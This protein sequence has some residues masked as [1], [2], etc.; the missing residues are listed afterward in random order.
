MKRVLVAGAI[1][2]TLISCSGG[3]DTCP[4]NIASY[5][6]DFTV[7]GIADVIVSGANGSVITDDSSPVSIDELQLNVTLDYTESNM[8]SASV[9]RKLRSMLSGLLVKPAFACS[10]R[11]HR[12]TTRVVGA[13]LIS[14]SSFN[15]SY[16]PGVSL[17]GVFS[18]EPQTADFADVQFTET[19][20]Q[21]SPEYPMADS[22][23]FTIK[24]SSLSIDTTA[25]HRFSLSIDLDNGQSFS[26]DTIA[27]LISG[28]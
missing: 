1:V 22:V 5:S 18:V 14:N 17:G 10:P 28:N 26:R 11:G 21:I 16:P 3:Q 25:L 19:L 27:A 7:I 12:L 8:D 24:P 4:A 20:D 13:R 23:S 6:K 2:I 9:N 15:E